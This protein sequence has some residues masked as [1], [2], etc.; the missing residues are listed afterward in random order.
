MS[1]DLEISGSADVAPIDFPDV[2]SR[3]KVDEKDLLDYTDY[4]KFRDTLKTRTLNAVNK[5]FPISNE[6]YTLRV[7]DLHYGKGDTYSLAQQ[8][9]AIL[10][11]Q[12]LTH[13]LKGNWEVVDNATGGVV[14]R[15]KPKTILNVPYITPRG[16]YIRRGTEYTIN[17]QLRLRPG[18]YS[19]FANDGTIETQFNVKH[20]TGSMFK[21]F[22]DPSKSLFY[23]KKQGKKIPM[24]PVLRAMGVPEENIKKAWGEEIYQANTATLRSPH[25]INFLKQY[26]SQQPLDNKTASID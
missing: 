16:T 26:V 23:L 13:T 9:K 3:P 12:S 18:V 7:A 10:D 15:S 17:K 2:P 25:A 22:M 24:L 6:K 4:D 8:K 1:E 5:A 21:T 19:R 11:K 20:G 14:K